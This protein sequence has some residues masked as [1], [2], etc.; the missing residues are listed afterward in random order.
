M[1]RYD[2][3]YQRTFERERAFADLVARRGPD[4]ATG[5]TSMVAAT[6]AVDAYPTAAAVFFGCHPLILLGAEV[7]G[8]AGTVSAAAGTLFALNLGT[9]I[10]PVGALVLLT[11]VANRWV[12]RWDL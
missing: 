4:P 2:D 3:D 12:F 8:G 5:A 6:A 11:F 7:E 10:P 9:T 1:I